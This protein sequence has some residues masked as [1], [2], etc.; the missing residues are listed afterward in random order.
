MKINSILFLAICGL[1]TLNSCSKDDEE[2]ATDLLTGGTW[3]LSESRS[4]IDG[5]G[6]L[7]S[8]IEDCSKDDKTTFEKEGTYKFD[9]GAT[10]CD[11]AD[12]QTTTGTWALSSD[13]KTLTVTES[14]LG[15][16][17]TIVSLTSNRLELRG[18][19]FGFAVEAVFTR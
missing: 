6:T 9:E 2:T 3:T 19:I 14:G 7:E 10:K 17:Y 8:D 16:A 11:P 18:E 12:P 15:L 4:D 13:E 5:D 1:L